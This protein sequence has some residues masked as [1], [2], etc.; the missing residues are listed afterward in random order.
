MLIA[1]RASSRTYDSPPALDQAL[2]ALS[3][4]PSALQV[5]LHE[6]LCLLELSR[7]RARTLTNKILSEELAKGAFGTPTK[8]YLPLFLKEVAQVWSS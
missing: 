7:F 1:P 8:I 3:P 6:E 2:C 4:T 5:L